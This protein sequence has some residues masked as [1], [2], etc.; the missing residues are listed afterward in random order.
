[1]L[2]LAGALHTQTRKA[3]ADGDALLGYPTTDVLN[4]GEFHLDVDSLGKGLKFDAYRSVGL[5]YG[6]GPDRDGLF[7]RTEVGFDY[8]VPPV[9][10]GFVSANSTKRLFFNV[11]T[12]LY[13]NTKSGVRISAGAYG[14]GSKAI[15]SPNIGYVLGSKNFK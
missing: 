6:L 11:E 9:A 1:M 8:L 4:K 12:Q 15:G 5:T 2:L 10:S 14:L 13:N 3:V 7:G